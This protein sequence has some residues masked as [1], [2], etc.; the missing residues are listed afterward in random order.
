MFNLIPK[1]VR[2]FDYF[3]QQSQHII[4]AAALLHEMV[5][6]FGDARAKAH[7]IKEVEHQG[8]QVTHEIIKKLNTTF[9][10]P[11]DREDIHQLAVRLDD[12]MDLI[13]GTVR[14]VVLFQIDK[15]TPLSAKMSQLIV[16]A[17]AELVEAVS[18]LRKQKGVMEHCIRIKK[19]ENEADAAYGE[20]IASLFRGQ[21]NAIELIKWKEVYDTMERCMDS[22]VAVAHVLESVVLKH[23]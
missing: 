13:D 6:N 20:S 22:S 7:A 9:I 15:P 11:I 16:Q 19:L 2:F 21:P 5:N 23:S 8:D 18:Q 4:R 17:S 3:E 12:V 10:T 1:E 14:R